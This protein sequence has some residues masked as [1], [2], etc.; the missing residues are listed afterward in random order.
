MSH[1]ENSNEM[2]PAL[3]GQQSPEQIASERAAREKAE[4][5]RIEFLAAEKKKRGAVDSAERRARQRRSAEILKDEV[6]LILLEQC[7]FLDETDC[8]ILYENVLKERIAVE[9]FMQSYF[10][11]SAGAK[12]LL[13]VTR[14]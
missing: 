10:G 6:V 11:Q 13:G 5:D 8:R 7:P 4:A 9:R 2:Y 14:M 3:G 12:A 1:F